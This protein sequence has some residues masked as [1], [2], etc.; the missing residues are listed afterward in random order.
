[1]SAIAVERRPGGFVH[2]TGLLAHSA[3]VEEVAALLVD[4][5][6]L[7][8]ALKVAR[9]NEAYREMPTLRAADACDV[10]LAEL[11]GYLESSSFTFHAR[12]LGPIAE[13]MRERVSEVVA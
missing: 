7:D 2:V 3:V 6:A 5:D 10:A 13:A 9:A 12:A 11:A 4:P 1:M 8:L